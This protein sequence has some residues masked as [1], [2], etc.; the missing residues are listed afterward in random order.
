L[1]TQELL[2]SPNIK[3]PAQ[4][5]AYTTFMQNRT[6]YER[7]VKEQAIKFRADAVEQN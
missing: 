7:R 5:E 6:E 2:D 1:G 4:A 3:D